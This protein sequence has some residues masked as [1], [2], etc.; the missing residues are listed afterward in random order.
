MCLQTQQS[1]NVPGRKNELLE[2][3]QILSLQIDLRDL[4]QISLESIV[5]IRVPSY[6]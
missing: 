6:Q 5:F 2:M 1:G 3:N 4:G